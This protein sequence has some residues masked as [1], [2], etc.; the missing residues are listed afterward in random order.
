MKNDKGL[1]IKN[2]EKWRVPRKLKKKIPKNT[3]YC[4]TPT[5]EIGIMNDGKL[6]YTIKRCSFYS[7]RK[8]K[9]LKPDYL[10]E[11]EMIK[12]GE[13][14]VGFCKLVKCEVNDQCKSCGIKY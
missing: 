1:F 8:I 3:H 13:E 6:G 7:W 4:Y 9:D 11:E 10:N 14:N 5:S 2:P 12:Y